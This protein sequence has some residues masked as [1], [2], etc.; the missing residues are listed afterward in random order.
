MSQ[1][2]RS[3]E[4]ARSGRTLRRTA[5]RQ[6]GRPH[7]RRSGRDRRRAGA[8]LP[9]VLP[10]NGRAGRCRDGPHAARPRYLRHRRRPPAGGRSRPRRGSGGRRR[11]LPADP[12]RG[13]Q[14]HRPF[15]LGGRIRHRPYRGV[16]RPH[17]GTRPLL[18]RRRLSQP[19]GHAAAVAR[20]RR[21][22]V[23]SPDRPDVRLRQPA[24][25]RSGRLGAGTDLSV[26]QSP[27][28]RR[29]P[30]ARAAAPLR[31]DAPARSATR[32]TPEPRWPGCRR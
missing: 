9:G 1:V 8:A 27:R 24:G 29:D 28:A 20:H 13:R 23:P 7:R 2:Q 19:R 10:G 14:P 21:L 25:H 26:P 4:S 15:L 32:S 30:A 31:R 22:C 18:R 11:H 16:P 12:A 17:P 3:D 5:R 6:S